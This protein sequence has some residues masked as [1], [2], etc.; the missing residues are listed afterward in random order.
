M[1]YLNRTLPTYY[2][3]DLWWQPHGWRKWWAPKKQLHNK[4]LVLL[5]LLL[6]LTSSSFSPDV[7][8][9]HH[10][11]LLISTDPASMI[12]PCH[13]LYVQ[14]SKTFL[15]KIYIQGESMNVLQSSKLFCYRIR[16]DRQPYRNVL[17]S[18]IN[19][20][21]SLLHD[22]ESIQQDETGFWELKPWCVKFF[23]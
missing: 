4:L 7:S 23:S 1:Q 19:Q 16:H 10:F 2:Q 20:I 9:S 18:Q 8:L 13:Q 17:I 3:L 21:F 15:Q 12:C 6:L 14:L 11:S 5:L 22:K